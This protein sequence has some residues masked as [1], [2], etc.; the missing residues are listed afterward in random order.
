MAEWKTLDLA[1]IL[2]PEV[3]GSL[4]GIQGTLDGLVTVSQAAISVLEFLKVFLKEVPHPAKALVQ[5]LLE[6]LKTISENIKETGAYGLFVFPESLEDLSNYRGGLPTFRQ[7]VIQSLYD[8]QDGNRPQVGSAGYLGAL[9]LYFNSPNASDMISS[10]VYLKDTI[11]AMRSV[12]ELKYPAPIHVSISPA[13]ERGVPIEDVLFTKEAASTLLLSWEEPKFKQNIFYDI[14]ARSKFYVERSKNREGI[15]LMQ[16]VRGKGVSNPLERDEDEPRLEPVLDPRGNPVFVWEPLD[17]DNP[18]IYPDDEDMSHG[19]LAGTYKYVLRNVAIGE[20]EGYYYRITSVPRDASLRQVEGDQ[21]TL[22]VLE[23]G[24]KRHYGSEPSL[25]VYGVL[26]A[27]DPSFDYPS[28]LLNVLRAAYLLRFDTDAYNTTGNILTGSSSITP[29][30][31]EGTIKNAEMER[32]LSEI[33]L[34]ELQA[35]NED[36]T[37]TYIP[38]SSPFGD[39]PSYNSTS[40]YLTVQGLVTATKVLEN[41]PFAGAAE[42]FAPMMGMSPEEILRHWIDREAVAAVRSLLSTLEGHESLLDLFRETYLEAQESIETVLKSE[43]IRSLFEDEDTR[44]ALFLLLQITGSP[45]AQGTPPNW[46]SVKIAEDLLPEMGNI[47]GRIEE[48]IG[49]L[50]SAWGG[51][52]DSFESAIEGAQNR[53]AILDSLIELLDQT[54]DYF[55]ILQSAPIASVLFIPPNTGGNNY[56]IRQ[57]LEA[58]NAPETKTSDYFGGIVLA[59]GGA[60]P[61]DVMGTINAIRFIFG[62]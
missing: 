40:R 58:D 29:S 47:L 16:E 37:N 22:Y 53:L 35:R 31:P 38:T 32:L 13:N 50:L 2:P 36:I 60:G 55:G 33:R 7:K 52:S 20:D 18:F 11:S 14:F 19:F 1:E 59:V 62:V 39:I 23:V 49:S 12:T 61:D 43:N 45:D 10:G 9:V 25:P 26:P 6:E 24:G 51:V 41:D 34:L 5:T 44:Q 48:S 54:L 42:M 8:T 30:F 4:G 28:A 17:P 15:P 27:T 46:R 21:G 3:G 56:L 57:L